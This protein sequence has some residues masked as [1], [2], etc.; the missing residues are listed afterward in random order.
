M[1]IISYLICLLFCII[2]YVGDNLVR[3]NYFMVGNTIIL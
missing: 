1:A 3:N 2:V